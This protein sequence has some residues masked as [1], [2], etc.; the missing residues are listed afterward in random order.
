MS[1]AEVA[2]EDR[3]QSIALRGASWRKRKADPT[4]PQLNACRRLR[5]VVPTG[6]TKATVSDLISVD[7]AS[8][9]IDRFIPAPV[10]TQV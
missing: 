6:A 3:G 5:L 10:P 8:R 4:E 2:A 9:A 1:W 7:L